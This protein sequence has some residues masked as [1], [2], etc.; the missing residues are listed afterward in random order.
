MAS[1]PLWRN[2]AHCGQLAPLSVWAR[3][4]ESVAYSYAWPGA[5]IGPVAALDPPAAAAALAGEL[6]CGHGAVS[7]RVPGSSRSLVAL[8][9]GRGLRLSPTPG[10][11][12][13]SGDAPPPTALAIGSFTL[14]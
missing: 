13:L 14:Y 10:L 4:G 2:G 9:L 5:A 7:V 11:L 1:S 3:G 12:L 8:A 6:A